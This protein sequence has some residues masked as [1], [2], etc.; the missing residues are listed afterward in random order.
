M[1]RVPIASLKG[2]RHLCNAASQGLSLPWCASGSGSGPGGAGGSGDVWF[3][4]LLVWI[5][6]FALRVLVWIGAGGRGSGELVVHVWT[7]VKLVS[8]N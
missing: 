7:V 2:G 1:S 5:L 8:Q 6:S 4:L 3:A